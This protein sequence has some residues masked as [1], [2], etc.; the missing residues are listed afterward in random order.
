VPELRES[1]TSTIIKAA[2][3]YGRNFWA[4]DFI[5]IYP[6]KNYKLKCID[7]CIYIFCA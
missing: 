5:I 4:F 7:N 1:T 3:L 2:N 6:D